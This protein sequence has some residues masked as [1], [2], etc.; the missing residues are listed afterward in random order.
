[1]TE[2]KII[3]TDSELQQAL[4]IL[5]QAEYVGLDTE[6]TGLDPYTCQLRLIQIGTTKHTFII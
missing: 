4:Q 3:K 1:M 5:T 2:I 6:T